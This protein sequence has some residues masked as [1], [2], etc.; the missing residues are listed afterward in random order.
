MQIN[1]SVVFRAVQTLLIA[2]GQP[3]LLWHVRH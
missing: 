3:S 1:G 2:L